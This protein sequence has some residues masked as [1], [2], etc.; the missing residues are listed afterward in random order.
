MVG[1]PTRKGQPMRTAA[2]LSLALLAAVPA[3]AADWVVGLGGTDFNRAAS[4]DQALIAIEVHSAPFGNWGPVSFSLAGGAVAHANGDFWIGGGISATAPLG[5]SRWFVEA[6]VMPGLYEEGEAV[7][8]LGHAIEI[9]SLI[10]LGY[11]VG[12]RTSLSVA[13]D[14]RSN[15]GLG[16]DNPGVNAVTLRLRRSY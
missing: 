14:H 5:A 15:A 3:Q 4:E 10:G 11:R 9:R 16:D 1:R 8:D 13:F 12:D 7:N 6:S 2:T